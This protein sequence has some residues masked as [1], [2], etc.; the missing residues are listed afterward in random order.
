MGEREGVRGFSMKGTKGLRMSDNPALFDVYCRLDSAGVESQP[1]RLVASHEATGVAE[2]VLVADA[3]A[4]WEQAAK[5]RHRNEVHAAAGLSARAVMQ[6]SDTELRDRLD[7]L[8]HRIADGAWCAVGGAGLD[9]ASASG[10]PQRTRQ[11]EALAAQLKMARR[12]DLPVLFDV[13]EAYNS[14]IRLLRNQGIPPRGGVVGDFDGSPRQV[15]P[16]LML[17]LDLS[18]GSALRGPEASR[19]EAAVGQVPRDRL[20]IESG[21]R[22]PGAEGD[23]RPSDDRGLTG[24]VERIGQLRGGSVRAVA[25]WTTENARGRL[26]LRG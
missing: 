9:F 17:D 19:V 23:K 13:T 24:V 22:P 20:L 6:L 7:E 5:L 12:Y 11:R 14:L 3:P 21:V 18:F 16:L 1:D 15:G 4:S 8:E 10:E 26:N 25:K 2:R